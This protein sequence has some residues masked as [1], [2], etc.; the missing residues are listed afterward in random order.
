MNAS[1]STIVALSIIQLALMGIVYI[2]PVI[3][4]ITKTTIKNLQYVFAAFTMFESA[5]VVLQY[6]SRGPLGRY[7]E[8]TL[9]LNLYGVTTRENSFLLRLSGTF[10]ESSILG[11]FM[12]MHIF[13]FLE[14]LIRRAY[15]NKLEIYIYV[16]S[17]FGAFVSIILTASRGI[18]VFLLIAGLI[19]FY[20]HRRELFGKILNGRSIK[21]IIL[22]VICS[23]VPFLSYL[24]SRF[25]TIIAIFAPGGSG[26]FRL[27]LIQYAI[28]VAQVNPFGVGLNIAPYVFAVGFPGERIFDPSQPHNMLFQIL[29]EMGAPGL[30]AFLLF[31]WAAFRNYI[32][33]PVS[34][35]APYFVSSIIFLFAAQLY[36]IFISQPEILS[37]FFLH[38]GL[39]N[40]LLRKKR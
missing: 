37:Y 16:L 14:L 18:Y 29:A 33:F 38:L 13:Y 11:T 30:I 3:I 20:V 27:A 5:W 24:I 1:F 32:R 12:L 7:L 39:M 17:I 26:D 4:G 10:F 19:F 40:W 28:R 34:R 8:A 22:A 25:Q 6:I 2:L 31:L 9:A 23:V 15:S 21:I 35:A 36:P